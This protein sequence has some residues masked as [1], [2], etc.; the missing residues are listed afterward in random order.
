MEN[1]ASAI[2]RTKA[3]NADTGD[4]ELLPQESRVIDTVSMENLQ[5]GTE[6][7]LRGVLMDQQTGEP[8]RE[9]DSADGAVLSVTKK[10]RASDA[11]MDVEMEYIFDAAAFAGRT[12]V[13][14]EYLYQEDVEI[15]RH[16]DL[17]DLMQQLYVKNAEVQSDE[18]ESGEA[19][20]DTPQTG[21]ESDPFP[22]AA[23]AAGAGLILVILGI[24]IR[25]KYYNSND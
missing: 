1:S 14:F 6:Y 4:Q 12:I 18:K 16:A 19:A 3:V 23:A 10:F 21:D 7:M 13:V 24:Y 8:L 5:T 22:I 11:K 25:R 2:V 17:E 15:S 20:V 9:N